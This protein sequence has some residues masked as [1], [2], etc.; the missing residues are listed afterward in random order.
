MNATNQDISKKAN[1]K[2]H[3]GYANIDFNYIEKQ[4]E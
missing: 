2:N 3:Y 4:L 1:T